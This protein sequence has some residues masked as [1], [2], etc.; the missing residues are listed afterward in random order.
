MASGSLGLDIF[1][2]RPPLIAYRIPWAYYGRC[3]SFEPAP[4]FAC[5]LLEALGRPGRLPSRP[6][7]FPELQRASVGLGGP[8][9]V[10]ARLLI[11]G[12]GYCMEY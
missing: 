4:L 6:R 3:K 5:G 9:H 2:E 12:V 7:T 10:E 8:Q 11:A 1:E